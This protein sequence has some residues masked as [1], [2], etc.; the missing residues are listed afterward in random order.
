MTPDDARS[1]QSLRLS[2]LEQSPSLFASSYQEERHRPRE[3]VAE[4]LMLTE[5]QAVFAAF[6]GDRLIG[7]AGMRRDVFRGHRHKVHLWG[8]YVVPGRRRAGVSRKLVTEAI[9][10]TKDMP[11]VTQVNLTVAASNV[12]AIRLY[13]SLGFEGFGRESRSIVADDAPDDDLRM[14]LRLAPFDTDV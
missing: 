11:G 8:V 1:F 3:D 13:R 5:K 14:C 10:F 12:I 7:V 9:G 4:W 6:K 2:A